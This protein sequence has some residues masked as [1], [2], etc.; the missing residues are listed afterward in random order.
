MALPRAAANDRRLH[1]WH[2][3]SV[4]FKF[5]L[6]LALSIIWAVCL[7]HV[8]RRW[9]HHLAL[10]E[11]DLLANLMIFCIAILPGA[12]HAFLLVG[13]LLD[14]RPPRSRFA[15]GDYPGVTL[16]IA[17]FN[18]EAHI[19]STLESI[20]RQC[21]PGPFEVLVI[22]DGSTDG[23]MERLRGVSYPWLHVI[24]L[25]CNGGKAK[26]LNNGLRHAAYPVTVTMN[27]S[28]YLYRDALRRLV[29]RYMSDPPNTA[30]VAG[31]VMVRN[32]RQS[33]ITRLQE[34]DHFHGVAAA[35][36][37][38][39]LFQGTLVAQSA[40]SLYRTDILRVVGGWPERAGEDTLLTWSILRDGHRVGYAEDAIAFANV[41]TT[42]DAL[43]NKQ[44]RHAH[45]LMEALKTHGALLLQPR[46]STL[47]VWW[48]LLLPGIQLAYTLLLI[49]CAVLAL[50]G[51]YD[52]LAPVA[53]LTLPVSLLAN[54]WMY[55]VQ[56][57]MYRAQGLRVRRNWLG[58]LMYT[59]IYGLALQPGGALGPASSLFKRHRHW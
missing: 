39:S 53:L 43:L 46:M 36:R 52:L 59:L 11:G 57:R 27:A 54:G 1:R 5:V 50:D 16:L 28:A 45:G 18:E 32:S 4:R 38:Q 23:T 2:D 17:A 13:L 6:T 35:K 41:P 42:F 24:D 10:L 48:S 14:R 44:R 7:Y 49:P 29:E 26:A 3:V 12:M 34:W 15:E 22:N 19:L 40:L 20:D 8:T 25:K 31:T 21:Y 47:F 55:R 33:L 37:L 51:V 30:A 9:T 58:L 56:S